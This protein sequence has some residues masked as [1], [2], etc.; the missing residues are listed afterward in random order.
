M[1]P[2]LLSEVENGATELYKNLAALCED[3]LDVNLAGDSLIIIVA[4]HIARKLS[5]IAKL[6]DF[7]VTVLDE[8]QEFATRERFSHADAVIC[9]DPSRVPEV[10]PLDAGSHVAIVTHGHLHDKDALRPVVASPALYV[11]VHAP[12]GL[13]LGGQTPAEISTS[14]LS[15]IIANAHGKL[16][17]LKV[18]SPAATSASMERP[19]CGDAS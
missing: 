14:I 18:L 11:R 4:G 7:P 12:I 3:F 5:P 15:E 1:P 10:I 8:R 2:S 16:D 9:G 17:S 6:L 13:D 19:C